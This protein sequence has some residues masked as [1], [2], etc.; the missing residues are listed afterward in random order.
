MSL[1]IH[2]LNLKQSGPEMSMAKTEKRV[3]GHF[4]PK[5]I[6]SNL[7]ITGLMPISLLLVFLIAVSPEEQYLEEKFGEAYKAYCRRVRRWI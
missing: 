6:L 2:F 4:R 1:L 7:W 3:K 5:G